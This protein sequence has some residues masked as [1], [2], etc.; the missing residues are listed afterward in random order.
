MNHPADGGGEGDPT[1]GLDDPSCFLASPRY[2]SLDISASGWL[3]TTP[4][5]NS[6]TTPERRVNEQVHE[7][8]FLIMNPPDAFKIKFWVM[9]FLICI[10]PWRSAS[11]V[12]CDRSLAKW[13]YF[14]LS[15]VKGRGETSNPRAVATAFDRE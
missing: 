11:V 6:S 1:V 12:Q 8:E 4:F 14:D 5:A 10:V 9:I 13:G 3:F 7:V 15:N 2:H